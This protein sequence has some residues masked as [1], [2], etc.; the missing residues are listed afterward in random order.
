MQPE[1]RDRRAPQFLHGAVRPCLTVL[2]LALFLHCPAATA[3]AVSDPALRAKIQPPILRLLEQGAPA[4]GSARRA[5]SPANAANVQARS[6]AWAARASEAVLLPDGRLL[7]FVTFREE[8]ASLDGAGRERLLEAIPGCEV[9]VDLAAADLGPACEVR[10]PAEQIAALAALPEVAY[11]GIPPRPFPLDV[12]FPTGRPILAYPSGGAQTFVESEGLAEMR[13]PEFWS[14]GGRGAGVR[15]G[16]I[17]IGFTGY[18]ERLG[19][20]LPAT[21]HTR[22]YYRSS[23]GR[24]DFSGDGEV[25]GTACAEILHDVAP[26]AELYLANA[27]TPGELQLATE[28]MVKEGVEIISHSV[29]WFLGAGDG[30]GPIQN[31]VGMA[32]EAGVIWVNAA[33]NFGRSHWTAP[34]ADSDLDDLAELN[35][36]G[37]ESLVLPPVPANHEIGAVL[38]WDKWPFS[39]DLAFE[40][41]LV[42][43]AGDILTSSA[44]DYQN[45]PYA[46][47]PIYYRTRL[48]QEGLQLRIRHTRGSGAVIRLRVIRNDG[49]LAEADQVLEGSVAMPADSPNALAVGAFSWG[50]GGLESFSSQGPTTTGLLKPEIL[51]PDGVRTSLQQNGY[52]PF[53]GTS[54]AC[55]HV[56]GA[57]ALLF[58]TGPPGAFF[59]ARW[60]IEDMLRA[61]RETAI[62]MTP[63]VNR[64]GTGWGRVRLPLGRSDFTTSARLVAL[65]NGGGGPLRLRLLDPPSAGADLQVFDVTGRLRG[66]LHPA[67]PAG[68]ASGAALEYDASA[69]AP[70]RLSRGIY[71]AR[72]PGTGARV[73]FYWPGLAP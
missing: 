17:D 43:S 31:I 62:P 51:G 47:R 15:L 64:A 7:C 30:T 3:G 53:Y 52:S 68:A 11:V 32:R 29:G 4:A 23:D 73:S 70:L 67:G 10:I 22:S 24:G 12:G 18:E 50:D 40:L 71:W 66:L 45:Y 25:H 39:T 41:E 6:S 49:D 2:L 38:L 34:F 19:R 61:L 20:E 21:V 60:S 8:A 56:A 48:A 63:D 5:G 9:H 27:G 57:L 72:E 42:N 28:W 37:A 13:V 69:L 65:G 55:P 54:A 14:F 44:Y 46:Y 1:R 16:I 35:A 59:D 58:S 33:G 26:Q 36:E